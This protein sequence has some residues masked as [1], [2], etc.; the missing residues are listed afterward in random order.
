MADI[1]DHLGLVQ[2]YFRSLLVEPDFLGVRLSADG[3]H[4]ILVCRRASAL[5]ERLH[6]D[7]EG[8]RELRIRPDVVLQF[9]GISVL[10]EDV[11]IAHAGTVEAG[12]GAYGAGLAGTGTL[13][14]SF[15]LDGKV[16][17]VSNWHVLCPAGNATK[18]DTAAFA[19]TSNGYYERVG[20]LYEFEHVD[21]LAMNRWDFA[22]LKYDDA[23]IPLAQMRQCADNSR[24]PYPTRLGFSEDLTPGAAVWKAGNRA[25]ICR[26]GAFQF[27]GS[28]KVNY[29]GKLIWF[30]DQLFFSKMSDPGDS[31]S[32]IVDKKTVKVLGLNFAGSE[33]WTIANPLYRKGWIP[34]GSLRVGHVDFPAFT[35]APK[36]GP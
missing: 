9:E 6:V 28:T 24:Y 36:K 34:A 16:V 5:A 14:W 22:L 13:G 2:D 33:K 21:D 19:R 25:P 18:I 23:A 8:Q 11:P 32:I 4:V 12:A 20:A 7:F 26:E 31:G 17:A 3:K 1:F 15:V 35:A 30:T 27:V 10:E 29:S